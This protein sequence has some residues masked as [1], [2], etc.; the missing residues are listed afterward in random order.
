M[1]YL[2]TLIALMLLT[3]SVP[4]I[5][6]Q[7][8]L[9]QSFGVHN[10]SIDPKYSADETSNSENLKVIGVAGG[11]VFENNLSLEVG[12]NWAIDNFFAARNDQISWNEQK[13]MLAYFQ[14]ISRDIG[15]TAK[16]G[17]SNWNLHTKMVNN[18]SSDA[19]TINSSGQNIFWQICAEFR[20]RYNVRFYVSYTKADTK[21]GDIQST[22][23]GMVYRD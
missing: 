19:R 2:G 12:F 16:V 7:V 21:F 9:S 23:F 14:G 13:I 22:E 8:K 10:L 3:L 1:K 5:A 11:Y 20:V 18:I 4:S 17:S 15:V 6:G